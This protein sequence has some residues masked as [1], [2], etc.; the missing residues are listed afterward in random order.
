MGVIKVKRAQVLSNGCL[1]LRGLL[2][3]INLP[4]MKRSKKL[5]LK[6]KQTDQNKLKSK[7]SSNYK[8]IL[9]SK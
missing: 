8:K 5:L 6:S 4:F 9:H 1:I 7:Y 3:K 2:D